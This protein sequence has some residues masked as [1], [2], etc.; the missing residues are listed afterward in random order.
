MKGSENGKGERTTVKTERQLKQWLDNHPRLRKKYKNEQKI[1]SI[2]LTFTTALIMI[3]IGMMTQTFFQYNIEDT[4]SEGWKSTLVGICI[5]LITFIW[6]MKFVHW[7]FEK[8][9]K[10]DKEQ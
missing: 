3:M 10:K 1:F 6:T 5:V 7:R 8:L 4:P 2:F 9:R